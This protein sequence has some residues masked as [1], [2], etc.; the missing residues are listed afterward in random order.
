MS[1]AANAEGVLAADRQRGAVHRRVAERVAMAL[2]RLHG[3]FRQ[4]DAADARVRAG[5]VAI[6]E[7]L[8]EP[9]ASKICA[10]Q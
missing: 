6:N 8:R 9:T 10:P 3:D 2:R 5:E 7:L 1:L 4:A